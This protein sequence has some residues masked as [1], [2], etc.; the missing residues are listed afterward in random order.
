L[1]IATL[2]NYRTPNPE[3]EEEEEEII[4]IP[5]SKKYQTSSLLNFLFQQKV[6]FTET[7]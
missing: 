5:T 6:W 4:N 7:S 2:L 1:T 3:E